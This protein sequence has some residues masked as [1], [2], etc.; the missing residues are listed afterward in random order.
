MDLWDNPLYPVDERLEMA[1]GGIAF[2]DKIITNLREQLKLQANAA[3][4]GMDAAKRTSGIQLQLAEQARAESSPEVLESERQVNSML[5]EESERLTLE[6]DGAIEMANKNALDASRWQHIYHGPYVICRVHADGRL[7]NLGGSY[8]G[9]YAV[10][11]GMA[12][13]AAHPKEGV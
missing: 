2:R 7:E 9:K 8:V 12:A 5:T 10:D 1:K 13:R 6:R 3:H 4:M 11:D